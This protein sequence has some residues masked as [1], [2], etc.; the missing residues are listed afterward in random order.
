[1]VVDR[2]SIAI[3]R[4]LLRHRWQTLFA[5]L[6]VVL[7]VTVVVAVDLANQSARR[8]FD[9]SMEQISG[10][11]SHQLIGGPNGIAEDFYTSLKLVHGYKKSAPIVEGDV[12]F[13]GENF[14]LIGLDY[15]AEKP[16]RSIASARARNWLG[17]L[18]TRPDTVLVPAISA[19][20]LSVAV[21]DPV[22][23][24]VAGIPKNVNVI[25]VF[26]GISEKA[27]DGMLIVDIA[28]AQELLG[29]TGQLDRIDL[30][31]EQGEEAELLNLLPSGVRLVRTHQRNRELGNLSN[32][33][34]TNLV[35]MSLLALLVGGFLIYNAISFSVLQR[36]SLIGVLR[37]LGAT[38]VQIFI[39]ILVE[40]LIIGVVGTTIGVASGILLGQGLVKLVVRTI[41]DLYFS[42]NVT[43]FFLSPGML[44]KGILLGL[45]VTLIAAIVPA[46][47]AT[48]SRAYAAV[49]RSVLEQSTFRAVP[50]LVF[51]GF[52]SIFI[53]ILIVRYSSNAL[54]PGFTG[55]FFTIA[56]FCL[57]VPA[58][59]LGMTYL[60]SPVLAK[61]FGV[62]G[63]FS[64]RGI[65]ASLSRTGL[66]MTALTLAIAVTIGMGVMV[67]SFRNTVSSWLAQSM[68]GDIYLSIPQR[69]SRRAGSAL[70]VALLDQLEDRVEIAKISY[71]RS[72]KVEAKSGS[73]KLLALE[74]SDGAKPNFVFKGRIL[75]ELWPGFQRGELVLI[76]ESYAFHHKTGLGEKLY[77]LTA[78]GEMPFIIGGVFFDYG[79]DSGM[80]VINRKHYAN[81]WQDNS[82]STV[83]IYLNDTESV[84]SML[85]VLKLAAAKIDPR[86]R[87]RSNAEIRQHALAVFDRT[88][89]ITR[90]LRLLVTMVA[91]VGILSALMSIQ[92]ERAKEHAVL[93][94]S[95]LTRKELM[96]QLS[97]QTGLMGMM[98]GLLAFPLGWLISEM[99]I[100]VINLRSFGWTLQ[101]AWAPRIY[102]ESFLLA[103]FAALLAGIYPGYRMAK[104]SIVTVLRAE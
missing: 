57:M 52:V 80:A 12:Q 94:A 78:K 29:R 17:A 32:A 5:V 81:L 31:L 7:G 50:W 84:N 30:I 14:T 71:G 40:A 100:H 19:T 35:A 33:F 56:G 61:L 103:L 55:L 27:L 28:A 95:G 88:F 16:F 54:I 34:Q 1:M 37:M 8:A 49:R 86:I 97:L 18:I 74:S 25:G 44:I 42:L 6:G 64:A 93:R 89:T 68:K 13:M 51:A 38:R 101:T 99:L 66:A 96:L 76:S 85:Q 2:L 24:E 45:A 104:A 77:L 102:I 91:F 92:F 83:G 36:R 23:I 3:F 58:L 15:F 46:L 39:R 65:R 79:S 4:H 98:A 9:L 22:K 41:N 87:V 60:I 11:S 26:G 69:S 73:I 48:H 70:P 90:V 53:G 67:D 82:I 59:A 47:E 20:R 75:P 63:Y 62:V 21:G 10:R 43:Q 72:V